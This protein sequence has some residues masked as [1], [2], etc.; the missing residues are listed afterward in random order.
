MS[1]FISDLSSWEWGLISLVVIV[2][3]TFG[4]LIESMVKRNANVKDSGKVMPGHGGML[5]RFDSA[6]FAAPFFWLILQWI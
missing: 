4:D 5:D 2:F 3:G 6:I 1:Q